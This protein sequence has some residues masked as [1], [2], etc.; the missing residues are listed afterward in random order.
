M[1]GIDIGEYIVSR[2]MRRNSAALPTVIVT[3]QKIDAS[4]ESDRA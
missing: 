2:K 3:P 4:I 1:S